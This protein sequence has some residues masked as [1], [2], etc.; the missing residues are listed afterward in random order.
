M[1]K[2]FA[3]LA[4]VLAVVSCQKDADLDVNVGGD[5][6]TISVA[7]PADAITRAAAEKTDSAWSGLQNEEGEV[8]TVTLYIFDENGVPSVEPY[9]QTLGENDL[10]ANFEVR[11]VPDRNYRF[12]AWAGQ[13]GAEDNF[14]LNTPIEEVWNIVLN[15]DWTA[16]NESRDA[17]TGYLEVEDFNSAKTIPTLELTRPFAKLRVITTDME[18]ITNNNVNPTY[19]EVS[20]E[21]AL[22]SSI[23][24]YTQT[25]NS[26]EPFAKKLHNTFAIKD[27]TQDAN[28]EM[29]LFTD[30]ILA[31]DE[32][33]SIH[34][35]M[36]VNDKGGKEIKTTEF[37]TDIPVQRN[38]LTTI[39]GNVLTTAT[40]INVTIDD[41]FDE[42]E[43]IP[44]I[45]FVASARELQEAVDACGVGTTTIV[46]EADLDG[47][48][49]I[50]QKEGVNIV[51]FGND[52]KYDGTITVNGDARYN[53]AET[54]KFENI[55]FFTAK[56]EVNFIYAPTKYNDRYNY[57]HNITVDGCTFASEAYNE[58]VV[59]VKL[60]TTYNAVIKNSTAKN[61]HRN[62]LLVWA[63]IFLLWKGIR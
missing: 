46:F 41:N 55:N 27:Y 31:E 59:G 49:V 5:V 52:Y 23:N 7:L 6:A 48:V 47:D 44:N 62:C 63:D 50:T 36:T 33:S 1:K 9:T 37:N 21:V 17:F 60:Q 34:F 16:M 57:S 10:V 58:N 42:P 30:Y 28:G 25:I 11:L 13:V 51:L 12:V 54:L 2:L 32:Q 8:M 3:L 14:T 56:E 53:G 4:V 39:I 35:T 26:N 20:Y 40:E 38:H 15:N 24:A 45:V 29:T 22:P 61:K 19:A 43:L 18:W